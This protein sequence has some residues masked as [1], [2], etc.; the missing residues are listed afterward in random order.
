MSR[1]S[2]LKN[3][4]TALITPFDEKE[5]VDWKV[6]EKFL[7]FQ[8]KNGMGLVPCGTT[9]ESATL[10][11]EE[12]H[13]IIHFTVKIASE[14]KEKAFVLAGTGS[15]STKEAIELTQTAEKAGADAA[16]LITPYYNKPTQK[17]LIEHFKA[18]AK[19]TELPILIYNVPG[20]TACNILPD[21]T[22]ELAKIKNI[23]GYKAADGNIDQI[24]QVIEKTPKDFIVMSGDDGLTYDIMKAGG[25]GVISVASNLAPAMVQKMTEALSAKK[26]DEGKKMSDDLMEL[27]KVLFVETSPG[28]VKYAAELMGLMN[29]RM[30]LPLVPP[31]PENQEKV[32]NS[33]KKYKLI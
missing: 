11:T 26:F 13:R 21:T 3:T 16:L 8:I 24:K 5:E 15:N 28:P 4:F 6:L 18:V 1:L 30:R 12:H 17:G 22:A 14:S 2:K 33:L 20:R 7:K 9:G 32:K 10:T 31:E 25:L 27:F 23:V 29:R 19:S